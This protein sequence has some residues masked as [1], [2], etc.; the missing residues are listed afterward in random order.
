MSDFNEREFIAIQQTVIPRTKSYSVSQQNE[1][2]KMVRELLNGKDVATRSKF[3]LFLKVVNLIS[4]F[5]A[6]KKF[7][8]LNEAQRLRVL[9]FFYD[10]PIGLFRKGFW[11]L[12]T[13]C[14]L[15]AYGQKSIYKD[16]HY[17]Q[18]HA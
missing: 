7:E 2:I 5:F 9:K 14:K 15:G 16:I 12:A 10:S 18:K 4:F 13:L 8:N 3:S 1:S 6:F 11:G 17:E